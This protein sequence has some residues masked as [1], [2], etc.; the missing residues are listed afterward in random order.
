MTLLEFALLL[1][2]AGVAGAIGQALAGYSLGGCLVSAVVGFVGA[3][4]GMWLART[5]GL[6]E[7]LTISIGGHPFPVV[8]SVIGSGILAFVVGLFT[9][10][11]SVRA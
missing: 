8:W 11:R 6:P 7:I 10:R 2:I 1:V 9:R 4:V 3:F 5:L